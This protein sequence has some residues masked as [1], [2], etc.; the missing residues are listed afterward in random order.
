[1]EEAGHRKICLRM[2]PR[3]SVAG[4]HVALHAELCSACQGTASEQ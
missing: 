2:R 3:R 1:M 4:R